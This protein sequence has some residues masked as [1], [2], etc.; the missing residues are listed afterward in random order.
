MALGLSVAFASAASAETKTLYIG[1]NGNME[2][3]YTEHVLPEF[4]KANDVKVVV[5]PGT[6]ADILAKATAQKDN[7]QM[8]VMLLDDGVMVR[9][10]S[11]GLC[12]K[13]SG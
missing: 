12:Q 10:I 7:P 13:I 3:A 6:S 11:S 2:K 1:M 4:E 8:H 5:V 9:A